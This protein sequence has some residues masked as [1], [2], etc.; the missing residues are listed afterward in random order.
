[1]AD[2]HSIRGKRRELQ[3]FLRACRARLRPDDVG[4]PPS[5]VHRKPGLRREDVAEL[6][7][8]TPNW[9]GWFEGGWTPRRFSSRF[10]ER[11]ADALRLDAHERTKLFRLA[12]PEVAAAAEQ[13]E[14][15]AADGA[16]RNFSRL[17]KLS[18]QLSRTDSFE[19]AALAAMETV[20][21]ILV[22]DSA[23]NAVIKM[24]DQSAKLVTIRPKALFPSES[25]FE[26]TILAW[27]T[28][29]QLGRT[30]KCENRCSGNESDARSGF[31]F[32]VE[33]KGGSSYPVN[34]RR[35][36]GASKSPF[37]VSLDDYR[38]WNAQMES[39]S[40]A[41]VGLFH[42]GVFRGNMIVLWREPRQ[43]SWEIEA[44]ETIASVLELAAR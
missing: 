12:L 18:R 4:L 13:L 39:R 22:P 5:E 1:M 3:D 16:F 34:V 27:T 37:V 7:G 15:S 23:T 36:R 35:S 44:L 41:V 21:D 24:S 32:E 30:T 8:V 40:G 28:P 29:T 42:S 19:D 6:A 11:V 17:R 25:L 26:R 43:L 38:Q 2:Y 20:Q 31:T 33:V 10:V 9:Y 14:K